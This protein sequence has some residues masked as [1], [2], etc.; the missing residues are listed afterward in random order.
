M[1]SKNF[2]LTV[3]LLI[4]LIAFSY[5]QAGVNEHSVK[6]ED[7]TTATLVGENGIIM[8]TTDMGATWLEQNS[9]ISNALFGN[10]INSG[11]SLAV[12]ENGVVLLS[13]DGGENWTVILP[14]TFENLNDAEAIDGI[15]AVVCGNAGTILYSSNAGLNWSTVNSGTL[16][17]LTDVKFLNTNIGYIS[18]ADGTLL[19]S[20]S[21]GV[22][23]EAIDMSFTSNKFNAVGVIDADRLIVV[24]DMG[25]LFMSGDG[26]ES[27]YGSAGITYEN[28]FN[29]VVF[30][31]ALN[32]VIAGN[33]G[34][35]LRT[36]DGGENWYASEVSAT[37]DDYDFFSVAFADQDNGIT[38]GR[39]G[40]E[41]YT[42]DG[43]QTWNEKDPGPVVNPGSLAND[44]KTGVK[45][46]QNYPNPFNPSTIINYELPFG[47]NV[48]VKVYDMLG[49]EVASLVS[50]YKESGKHSVSFNA[51]GLS[52]G[53]YF[54]KLTA[55]GGSAEFNKVMKMIL[56]K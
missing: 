25:T 44:E 45:L 2:N 54:Y 29:D 52:S 35:I 18:G 10:S 22:S 7:A 23:W 56:T 12:G 48:S 20:T 3:F 32:G 53:V 36:N 55:K 15:N 26:G 40:I 13:D 24:G 27:W 49:K 46:A 11:L 43:G 5:A 30:F 8:R 14:G 16:S 50:S 31:D 4:V 47:A 28:D 1:F 42:T 51:S 41:V 34:L 37:G 17:N 33:D 39:N 6:F 9:N 38:I 19:R 21:G